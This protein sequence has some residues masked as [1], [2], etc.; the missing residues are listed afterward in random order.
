[1]LKNLDLPQEFLERI[2]EI[3]PPEYHERLVDFF[4]H[5]AMP[6]FRVNRL[7]A[8]VKDVISELTAAGFHPEPKLGTFA[9]SLPYEEREALTHHHLAAG[10]QIYIQSLAS[11]AAVLA[12][13]VQ[14]DMEVLDTCAAPGGKTLL[15]AD[16]LQNSGRLAAVEAVRPRFFKLKGQVEAAGAKVA[17]YQ[18]DA[19]LLGRKVPARFDRV[20]VDAPCSSEARFKA[21]DASTYNHWNMHKIHEVAGKQKAI[22]AAACRTLKPGGT[23]V[24]CTCSFAPEENEAQLSAILQKIPSLH[25]VPF[26]APLPAVPGLTAWRGSQFHAECVNSLRILPG[27]ET[28]GLFIAK[29]VHFNSGE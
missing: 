5:G 16:I 22:L 1:M 28:P 3:I 17:L 9:F 27:R 25:C 15:I 13:D 18:S 20:L 7:K 14:P 29:L 24:Y 23:L 8:T 21:G 26:K 10:G 19:R 11:M 4:T 2:E 12:L 6:S